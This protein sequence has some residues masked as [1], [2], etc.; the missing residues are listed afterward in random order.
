MKI[1]S[2]SWSNHPVLGDLEIDFCNPVDSGTPY[3]NIVLIGENGSGK[4]NVLE[5][6]SEFLVGGSI[7]GIASIKYVANSEHLEAVPPNSGIER[8]FYDVVDKQGKKTNFIIGKNH[9]D[10]LQDDNP[11]NIRHDGCVYSKARA[12]YRTSIISTTKTSGL[13][14]GKHDS[15][16]EQ[17]FTSLKQLL[18]DI[19]AQDTNEYAEQN[20]KL[21]SSPMS[22]GQF[23]LKSK[24]Y[25]F[26]NAFDNFFEKITF[27]T[28]RDSGDR[29][30]VY[31]EKGN[32]EISIDQLSTGEKQIVFRG[33]FLLKNIKNLSEAVVMID[34]PELSMHPKW[35]Q[36]I[37]AYY[38]ELFSTGSTQTAQII[39]ASHSVH[40]VQEALNNS[41]TDL[42]V[43]LAEKNGAITATTVHSP[44]VL[45]NISAAETN[46]HAFDLASNDYHTELYGYLQHKQNALTVKKCD[47]FI[48]GNAHY[49]AA[50]HAKP[51]QGPQNTTYDTLP[52]FVRNQIHHPNGINSVTEEE[53]RQS[54]ELLIKLCV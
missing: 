8:G 26:K 50:L 5:S 31:F 4:T 32:S 23:D 25:R 49:D 33:C 15:D 3:Q 30:E 9:Q 46:Y 35:E 13:D 14:K 19:H 45:P 44:F 36:K 47:T 28:V 1:K 37:L 38:K 12:D 43:V 42:V 40:V 29:K 34:E 27:K 21:E 39:F 51:S 20:K 53:L 52:K 18:V 17:D 6:I 41:S 2:V 22:W 48:K 54:I 7:E 24:S 10:P 11:L 16:S